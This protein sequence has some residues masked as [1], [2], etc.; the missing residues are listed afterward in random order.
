MAPFAFLRSFIQKTLKRLPTFLIFGKKDINKLYKNLYRIIISIDMDI[1]RL[2]TFQ[3][4]RKV[5]YLEYMQITHSPSVQT[6][7]FC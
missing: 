5:G 1:R 7:S 4:I 3:K 2:Q 6:F